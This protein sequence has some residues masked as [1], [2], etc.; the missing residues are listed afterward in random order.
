M[1]ELGNKTSLHVFLSY[2]EEDK[3]SANY[4]RSVLQQRS[5]VH[6]FTTDK[7]SA[8]E[9]WIAQLK[10]AL[11]SCDLFVILV[12]PN[13]VKSSW[14]LQELGAAW[15]LN[16]SILGI[17]S[18]RWD[19]AYLPVALDEEQL[20]DIKFLEHPEAIDYLLRRYE[21]MSAA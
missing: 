11:S 16:K 19:V 13:A 21:A 20:V 7:L 5:N 3:D 10:T 4:L 12:T 17:Y 18:D 14:V 8:G 15:G 9:N 6:V 1:T 2:A